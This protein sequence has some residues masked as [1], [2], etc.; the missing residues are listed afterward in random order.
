[1]Q[2]ESNATTRRVAWGLFA[3]I[4]AVHLPLLGFGL[5]YDDGWT[6]RAN[7]F[8]R[9]GVFELGLLLSPE[10]VARHVPDAFRPT[11]VVFDM[12]SYRA[13]GLTPWA[14]HLIS[15]LLHLGVC[16]LLARLLARLEAG[17]ELRLASVAVFGLLAIHAEAVAVVSFREDLL[18]ALLGLAALLAALRSIADPRRSMRALAWLAA[19]ILSALACG[20]KLS[21]AALPALLPLLA[22]LAPWPG[23]AA[24]ADRRARLL[25]AL[26]ALA[27]GVALAL[28]QNFAVQGSL[29]P[30]APE[31][32][33][34]VFAQRV[35][36]APV[37]AASTQ[38]HLGY[39][40]QMLVPIGLSPEYV[41]FAASWTDAATLL[42][43][44]VFVLATIAAIAWR[45]RAPL[46][47]LAWLGW[48]ALALPTS[49]LIGMPN[50]RA[51]RFMYLPSVPIAIGLAAGLLALGRAWQ[52]REPDPSRASQRLALPLIAF[53]V[54]QGSFG[55]AAAR[56]YVSN[57]TLWRAAVRRAPDSARARAM[58][59]LERLAAGRRPDRVEPEVAAVVREQCEHARELDPLDE[60]PVICLAEL[61]VAE[62]DWIAAYDHYARA[63]ELG[64]DRQDRPIAALAQLALDQP[65]LDDRRLAL[66][67]LA[68][69]LSAYPY[70]PDLHAAAGR[71]HHRLGDP[72]RARALYRR[73]RTLRPERWEVAAWGVELALDLG[74]T[75]AAHRTWWAEH[76]LLAGADPA[77]RD[78]LQ[79]RLA[80]A[81]RDPAFSPLQSFLSP[82]VFPD[83]P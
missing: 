48:L 30:Y 2:Q 77:T 53:V 51:D 71:I 3:L 26:L 28:A 70:S 75:A 72:E 8:L 40:A 58:L 24:L 62:R 36:L 67:L 44:L 80:E 42:A 63:V 23:A 47:A 14:H 10:A 33:P 46:L 59:G 66:D 15:I 18:A 76:D 37:L 34:R 79:R 43:L 12:L 31:L 49:N 83:E 81:R 60:L 16:A 13:I 82:G 41:D 29:S 7:G 25:A 52:T 6:L 68:R 35:G 4:A 39:L 38:I 27:L 1:M 32:N 45:R 65:G 55:L 50:M 54:I 78:L 20:A 9:P 17:L 22:W 21:A 69:G 11:L 57:A 61:A 19:L 74:E 64:V 73:A 56:A 5:V